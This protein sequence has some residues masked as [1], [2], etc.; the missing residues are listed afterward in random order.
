MLLTPHPVFEAS[1]VFQP[2]QI[3]RHF[4]KV[5]QGATWATFRAK[6]LSPESTGRFILHTIQLLP[7]LQVKTMEYY[8]MFSLSEAGAWEFAMP[9]KSSPGQVMEFCLAK[10]WAN[11]GT[12]NCQYTITFHGVKPTNSNPP[13]D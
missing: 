9:V 2:G 4:V 8:K 12:L 10:W 3:T 13:I 11:I 7:S 5:P 1:K 6:N